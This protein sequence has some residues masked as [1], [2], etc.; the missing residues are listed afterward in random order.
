MHVTDTR[1]HMRE[2]ATGLLQEALLLILNIRKLT[3]TS[4]PSLTQPH[5]VNQFTVKSIHRQHKIERSQKEEEQIVL[6]GDS[7]TP[8]EEMQIRIQDVIDMHEDRN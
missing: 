1:D 6:T 7:I 3:T 5:D 4:L 2:N 8:P